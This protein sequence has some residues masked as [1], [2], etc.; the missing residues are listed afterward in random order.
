MPGRKTPLVTDEIYH[1]FNRGINRTPTF[2]FKKDYNRA[3]QSLNYYRFYSPPLRYS[4]FLD[5]PEDRKMDLL[6]T[7]ENKGSAVQI[8][9]FCLMPNHFH[10]LVKQK[11]DNGISKFMGNF[12]N[13][14]TR[15]FNTVH[16]RDGSLF[17]DQFKAVRI[18]SDNQLL[19]VQRYL[20]LNPFTGFV[21]KSLTELENYPWSSLTPYL[22]NNT[23]IIEP[24]LILNF[25]K[26]IKKYKHF[27][28]NQA[29]YQRNLKVI[30]HLVI[31]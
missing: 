9:A 30:E 6:K 19:H 22:N 27:I 31:E 4:K 7:M 10:L 11:K 29:D 21:V 16:K 14:Y 5:L 24:S 25:F 1:V 17:L 8:L 28:F 2:I 13:S 12:Q 15:Y 26:S 23:A 18:E 20:H 3:I